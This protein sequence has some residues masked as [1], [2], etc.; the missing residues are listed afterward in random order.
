[1]QLETPMENA[2]EVGDANSRSVE[3]QPKTISRPD[4]SGESVAK[5]EPE[6]PAFDLDSM[7]A[8]INKTRE[9]QQI[10]NQQKALQAE[11]DIY[12]FAANNREGVGQNTSLTMDETTALIKSMKRC[13]TMPA[14]ME[15]PEELIVKIRVKLR[16]DGYVQ[17]TR[18]VDTVKT[19]NPHWV[20][21]ER[22]ARDAI[23]KCE[24]YNFLPIEKYDNWKDMILRFKPEM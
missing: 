19:N 10:V 11:R 21:A 13:W 2:P 8:L 6:T 23:K 7:E 22:N 9:T 17:E 12:E 3:S 24:P 18:I 4:T 14:G 20:F 16:S 5:T 1:M 15:N